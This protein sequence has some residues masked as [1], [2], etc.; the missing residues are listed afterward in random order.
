MG[1]LTKRGFAALAGAVDLTVFLAEGLVGFFG[2]AML[3]LESL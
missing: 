3:V 2:G 1:L